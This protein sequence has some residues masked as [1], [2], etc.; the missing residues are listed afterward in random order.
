MNCVLVKEKKIFVLK[1][2]IFT[3]LRFSYTNLK[4]FLLYLISRDKQIFV[5]IFFKNSLVAKTHIF[6]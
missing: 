3:F 4:T 6:K 5:N 1:K 2:I